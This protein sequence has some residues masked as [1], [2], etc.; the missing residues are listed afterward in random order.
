MAVVRPEDGILHAAAAKE[1]LL[2][3]VVAKV[4]EKPKLCTE[5]IAD[6]ER[7]F[8]DTNGVASVVA[9]QDA[10]QPFTRQAVHF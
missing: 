5:S 4:T 6:I 9:S 8:L 1:N 3:V 2:A 10:R 7:S